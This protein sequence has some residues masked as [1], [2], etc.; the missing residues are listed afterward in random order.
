MSHHEKLSH[1]AMNDEGFMFDPTT[2]DSFVVNQTAMFIVQSLQDER[3]ENEI[4]E[5]LVERY[6]VSRDDALRD[7]AD[8]TSRLKSLQLL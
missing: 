6:D 2:G 4:A 8:F 1:L 7:I 5:L 3:T